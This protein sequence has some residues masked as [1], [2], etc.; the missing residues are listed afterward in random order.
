MSPNETAVLRH[1]L[2]AGRADKHSLSGMMDI[3]TDCADYML[4]RLSQKD[5]LRAAGT[6]R[7][8]KFG[9]YELTPKGAEEIL[10]VLNFIK[11]REVYVAQRAMHAAERVDRRIEECKELMR[12]QF[13]GPLKPVGV[14]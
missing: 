4:R 2:E 11:N 13:S 6:A 3:S 5:C 7:P 14:D 12:G 8:S 1:V 10:N 9:T